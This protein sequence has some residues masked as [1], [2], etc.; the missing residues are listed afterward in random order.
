MRVAFI[1]QEFP[2]LI[3]GGAGTYAGGLVSALAQI[4]VD[5][6]VFT[7]G[8][9]QAG[10]VATVAVSPRSAGAIGFWRRLPRAIT[11]AVR[12]DGAFDVIHGNGIADLPLT[13][14][15]GRGAR[16]VTVNHVT[17]QLVRPGVAGLLHRARDIR[18]ET[19]LVPLVEGRVMRRA[20]RVIAI[21]EMTHADVITHCGVSENRATVIHIGVSEARPIPRK[22]TAAVR[23]ELCPPGESLVLSMGRME[24]RKG[25]DLLLHAFALLKQEQ[26]PSRLILAGDGP[27][28]SYRA[29]ARGLGIAERVSFLGRVDDDRRDTLYAA[30]DV[31]V[32]A[33]RLEGFGL[34]P[35]EAM[36]FGKPVV[37]T[38]TGA[39]SDG[40]I[41]PSHGA[42]VPV[43]NPEAL[44]GAIAGLLGNRARMA[45]TG[46]ANRDWIENNLSWRSVAL[47]T[48]GVYTQAIEARETD[49]AVAGLR[50]YLGT[51]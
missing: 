16:V 9:A 23:A 51:E 40:L 30:C 5:V 1:S 36:A 33:S 15:R 39:A 19:G 11:E 10:D 26:T 22:R 18:G 25:T 8:G 4:G 38:R 24:H 28:E 49:G 42:V 14:H 50:R 35:F 46:E 37:V 13:R 48:V 6:T 31:F 12:R 27:V 44:A 20:D 32:F 3:D 29:I 47:R 41:K 45:T 21:S 7:V 43:D 34:V 17:R 2:P